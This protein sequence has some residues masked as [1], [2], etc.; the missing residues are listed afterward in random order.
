VTLTLV[1]FSLLWGAPSDLSRALEDATRG[2]R[3]PGDTVVL[4]GLKRFDGSRFQAKALPHIVRV[5][6]FI[7]PLNTQ[8]GIKRLAWWKLNAKALSPGADLI[9]VPSASPRSDADLQQLVAVDD[10]ECL[11]AARFGSVRLYEGKLGALPLAFVLD[12][13]NIVR[14][15]IEADSPAKQLDPIARAVKTLR[16]QLSEQ[17]APF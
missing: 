10:P 12:D 17:V 3:M 7:E 2:A 6:L 13:S 16:R 8:A 1:L 11:L 14:A 4:D 9:V 15:I 5:V